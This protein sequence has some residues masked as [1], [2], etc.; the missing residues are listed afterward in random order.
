MKVITSP[1]PYPIRSLEK[2]RAPSDVVTIMMVTE[3]TSRTTPMRMDH[4]REKYVLIG[5]VVKQAMKAPST[6]KEAM[7]CWGPAAMF[8]HTHV[9]VSIWPRPWSWGSQVTTKG[10][11]EPNR[12]APAGLRSQ[13]P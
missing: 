5:P 11:D 13:T 10:N 4:R 8:W 2:Y 3:T 6:M 12:Q 1:L 7:I 9:K